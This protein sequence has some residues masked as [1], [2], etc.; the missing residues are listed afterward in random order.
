VKSAI[1]HIKSTAWLAACLSHLEQ[2]ISCHVCLCSECPANVWSSYRDCE[3][4]S[5]ESETDRKNLQ[6]MLFDACS[7]FSLPFFRGRNRHWSLES[8]KWLPPALSVSPCDNDNVKNSRS[9]II[10]AGG[11][12]A[13]WE[14]RKKKNPVEVEARSEV[15]IDDFHEMKPFRA[16]SLVRSLFVQRHHNNTSARHHDSSETPA[17]PDCRLVCT[18]SGGKIVFNW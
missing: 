11:V 3:M 9:N 18:E 16:L 1:K 13:N 15:Y 14:P 4:R 17:K 7:A 12:A 6:E 2:S 10:T 5:R 8:L